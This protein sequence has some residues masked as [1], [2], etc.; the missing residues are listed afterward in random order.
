MGQRYAGVGRAADRRRDA[1]H[2]VVVDA[3]RAQILEFLAAPAKDERIAA[4]QADD[5]VAALGV[6]AQQPMD[7]F[8]GDA[9]SAS[10]FSDFDQL[11][12]AARQLEDFRAD[13]AVV[14]DDVGRLQRAQGIQ[15]QEARVTR[16]GANQDDAPTAG[17]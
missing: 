1:R 3:G 14:Q 12:L 15:R 5:A 2:D 7:G 8:L 10:G 17:R 16:P 4:F 11:R 9:V 6:F 13:Q